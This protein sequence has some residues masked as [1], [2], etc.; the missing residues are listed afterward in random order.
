MYWA[1]VLFSVLIVCCARC[2]PSL[3]DGYGKCYMC[4]G[5]LKVE[6]FCVVRL[7]EPTVVLAR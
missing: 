1:T 6:P 5:L 2:V 3:A 7:H 4:F